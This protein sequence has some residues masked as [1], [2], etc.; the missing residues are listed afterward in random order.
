MTPPLPDVQVLMSG[1]CDCVSRGHWDFAAVIKELRWEIILDCLG[2]FSV[3]TRVLIRGWQGQKRRC[4][5]RNRGRERQGHEL[6][7]AAVSGSWKS[8]GSSFCPEP[9]GEAAL[10]T[11]SRLPASTAAE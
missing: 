7:S 6:R 5:G 10:R 4:E 3:I 8:P 1:I 2:G 9:P 11:T